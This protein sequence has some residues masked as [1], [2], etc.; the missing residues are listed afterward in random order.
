MSKNLGKRLYNLTPK[1]R[2]TC[3][4]WGSVWNY[5]MI[6]GNKGQMTNNIAIL[7]ENF[8]ILNKKLN[9][10]IVSLSF[11]LTSCHHVSVVAAR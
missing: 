4:L 11:S 2:P 7:K 5:I 8:V 9:L 3:G 1:K 10:N 6:C